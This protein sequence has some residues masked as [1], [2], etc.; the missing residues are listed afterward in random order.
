MRN[1][2][3]HK[4]LKNLLMMKQ[5]MFLLVLLTASSSVAAQDNVGEESTVI[6][7]NDYFAQWSPVRAKDMIDRIS[8]LTQGGS[9]RGGFGGSQGGFTGFRGGSRGGLGFGNGNRGSEILINGKR[10]AGKN[11]ST[12][13]QLTR[14]TSDQVNYIEIIRGTS[15]E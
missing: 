2:N 14:I 1:F 12:A 4:V 13:T 11:N 9:S 6:Y 7:S 10:T 8:G 5:R 3:I 15:R